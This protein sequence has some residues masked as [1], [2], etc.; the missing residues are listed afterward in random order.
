MQAARSGQVLV[1]E[2]QDVCMHF[3]DDLNHSRLKN[4]L[5]VLCDAVDGAS[6]SLQ[7]VKM[8]LLALNTTS[9]LFSEVLQL[10][11]LLYVVPASTATAERTFSSLRRL[12]TFLRNSM[13]AQRLNHL[14]LLHVHKDITDKLDLCKVAAE[15]IARNER[16]QHVFG[17]I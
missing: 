15:F 11:R 1:E 16:R 3:G 8:S 17:N 6:P 13:S 10:L 5:A 9:S 2:L 14:I 12:K 4:Q 7:D